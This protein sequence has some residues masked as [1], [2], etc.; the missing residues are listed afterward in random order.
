MSKDNFLF[1]TA[2]PPHAC[3]KSDQKRVCNRASVSACALTRIYTTCTSTNYVDVPELQPSRLGTQPLVKC[4]CVAFSG[5]V[6]VSLPHRVSHACACHVYIHV[7]S[8]YRNSTFKCTTTMI[9]TAGPWG[10]F[11]LWILFVLGQY[12]K[13]IWKYCVTKFGFIDLS[14]YVMI[15]R[16]TRECRS[17]YKKQIA[18]FSRPSGFTS[19]CRTNKAEWGTLEPAPKDGAR[20]ERVDREIQ[21]PRIPY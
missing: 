21:V 10:F 7:R 13:P 8:T 17:K 6:I 5:A 20:T 15:R 1:F 3:Y 12:L 19:R 11:L 2:H 18:H 4:C 9:P 16:I 14:I